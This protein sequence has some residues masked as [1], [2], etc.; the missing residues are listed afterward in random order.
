MRRDQFRVMVEAAQ[1][2]NVLYNGMRLEIVWTFFRCLIVLSL[3]L[4]HFSE[5]M[6][7]S[8]D[9]EVLMDKDVVSVANSIREVV[10]VANSI[11]EVVSVANAMVDDISDSEMDMD[12]GD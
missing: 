4:V 2:L 8:M 6:E 10:S 9:R 11:R 1:Q 7:V 5:D 12:F 3:V